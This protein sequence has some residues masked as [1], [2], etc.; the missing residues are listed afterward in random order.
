MKLPDGYIVEL[1]KN[2][3]DCLKSKILTSN[4]RG[5]VKLLSAF[6]EKGLYMPATI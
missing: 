3:W 6:I 1:T 5:K 2:E 4:K